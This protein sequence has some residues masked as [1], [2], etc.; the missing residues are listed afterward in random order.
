M[1]AQALDLCLGIN[2]IHARLQLVLDDALGTWHGIGHADFI[3]LHALAQADGGRL[4]TA[5]LLYQLAP[6]AAVGAA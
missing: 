3:L 1:S 5:A 6:S 2:L 4:P